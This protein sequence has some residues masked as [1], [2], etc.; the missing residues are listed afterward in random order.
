VKEESGLA[1]WLQSKE[2]ASESFASRRLE[3]ELKKDGSLSWEKISEGP[4]MAQAQVAA[5]A[6]AMP[7]LS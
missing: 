3:G 1:G 7:K 6:A 2:E 5:S 4:T